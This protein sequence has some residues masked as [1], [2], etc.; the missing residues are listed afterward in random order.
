MVLQLI[1]SYP[2]CSSLDLEEV[3]YRQTA[4]LFSFEAQT[5]PNEKKWFDI[6]GT[7]WTMTLLHLDAAGGTIVGSQGAGE[8]YWIT[9]RDDMESIHNSQ[10]Y[11]T[12]NPDEPDFESGRYEGIVLPRRGGVL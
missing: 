8:K 12:W 7:K 1:Q 2:L 10:T 3:A 9:K 11:R 4:G 5:L 6:V